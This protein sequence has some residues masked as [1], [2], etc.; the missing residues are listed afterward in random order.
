MG[1]THTKNDDAFTFDAESGVYV[2]CD[3]VSEGGQGHLASRLVSDSITQQVTA[4]RSKS[5]AGFSSMKPAER[6]FRMQE[7]LLNA[8]SKAQEELI[9][10]TLS[11]PK[12]P[13][14]LAASTGVALWIEDRIGL[15]AHVGDSRAYLFRGVN[16]YQLTKDHVGF[17]ELVKAGMPEAVARKHPLA[18]HLAR[19]FGNSRFEL[20]DV[21]QL[22]FQPG[23]RVL[24]MT[25]GAYRNLNDRTI[26]SLVKSLNDDAELPGWVKGAAE[27]VGDDATVASVRFAPEEQAKKETLLASERVALIEGTPLCRYMNEAQ[28]LQVAAISEFRTAP[29]GEKI[30]SEGQVGDELYVLHKGKVEIQRKQKSIKVLGPG[31]F[32]GE[33][34]LIRKIKRTSTVIA[35]GECQLVVLKGQDL[36]RLFLQDRA[37]ESSV[38]RAMAE[39]LIDRLVELQN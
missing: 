8:F 13:Y 20:P 7:V 21:L 22:E 38:L 30:I 9:L 37:L 34:G 31:S 18:N 5:M 4:W 10:R 1:R 12:S 16:L 2:V 24:L 29:A 3:G 35:Q 15:I 33:M 11:D 39:E 26:P 6:L 28:K 32:F 17:G 14:R 25:D 36:N 19:A 27:T 23:D